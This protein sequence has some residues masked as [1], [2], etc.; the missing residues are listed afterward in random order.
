[1]RFLSTQK[2]FSSYHIEWI[3]FGN[4][5]SE[6]TAGVCATH[7]RPICVVMV[8]QTGVRQTADVHGKLASGDVECHPRDLER[9]YM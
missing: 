1:M 9:A 3:Q 8:C 6:Q 7:H 4:G 2:I 5:E